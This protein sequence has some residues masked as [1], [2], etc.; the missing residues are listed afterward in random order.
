MGGVEQVGLLLQTGRQ[1]QTDA[2]GQWRQPVLC[3]LAGQ[4][5]CWTV[6]AMDGSTSSNTGRVSATMG[7]STKSQDDPLDRLRAKR[8][9]DEMTLARQPLQLF[10]QVIM[11]YPG[12]LGDVDGNFY[13]GWH[14]RCG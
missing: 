11:E 9:Q 1:H 8:H 3:H 4:A 6:R 10:G 7:R 5:I 13:V 12:D 2:G 14:A